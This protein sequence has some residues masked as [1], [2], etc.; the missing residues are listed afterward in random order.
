MNETL[1]LWWKV[2]ILLIWNQCKDLFFHAF[3]SQGHSVAVFMRLQCAGS[4]STLYFNQ[5]CSIKEM[6][7]QCLDVFSQDFSPW[8]FSCWS[9]N[10][11]SSISYLS[12]FFQIDIP[13]YF[14]YLRRTKQQN[15]QAP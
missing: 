10:W 7:V 3:C 11:V 5:H 12:I 1:L 8:S 9:I 13:L 14:M 6:F 2:F 4:S 15:K